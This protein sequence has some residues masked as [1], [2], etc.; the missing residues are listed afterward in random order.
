MKCWRS[1]NRGEKI[2]QPYP[3]LYRSGRNRDGGVQ[4]NVVRSRWMQSTHL[5]MLA[6]DLHSFLL[7]AEMSKT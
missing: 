7:R 3:N 2:E 1:A 5:G 4:E 6:N